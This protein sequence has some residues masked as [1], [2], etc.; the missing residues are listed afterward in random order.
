MP[1]NVTQA[2]RLRY[3]AMLLS[4]HLK[5]MLC[6]VPEQFGWIID[7]PAKWTL[8]RFFMRPILR[9]LFVS[10]VDG[11]PHRAGEAVLAHLRRKAGYNRPTNFDPD[12]HLLAFREGVRTNVQDLFTLLNLDESDVQNLMELDDGLGE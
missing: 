2:N 10:P 1:S 12:P 5:D 8:R 3:R 7:E 4:R 11:K 9:W 6:T